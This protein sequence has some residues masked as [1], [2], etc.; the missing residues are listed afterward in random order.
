[1]NRQTIGYAL[2]FVFGLMAALQ[3]ALAIRYN[4]FFLLIAGLFALSAYLIWY[5]VS[6]LME[7]RVRQ[8]AATGGKPDPGVGSAL[9]HA[10]NGFARPAG[11]RQETP[12]E[13]IGP[14]EH[15][16]VPRARPLGR[17]IRSSTSAPTPTTR[18]SGRP[19][20]RK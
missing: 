19:T 6:G 14:V 4:L 11:V 18:R 13:P 1:M 2:V 3:T 16:P 5:H 15:R 20:V 8:G 17:P 12:A 7:R 10:N 9:D